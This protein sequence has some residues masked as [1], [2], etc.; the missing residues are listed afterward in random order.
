[1]RRRSGDSKDRIEAF[2]HGSRIADG[3]P[4]VA[5]RNPRH[6]ELFGARRQCCCELTD[7]PSSTAAFWRCR[8]SPL[9]VGAGEFVGVI[10][11]EPCREVDAPAS[12]FR[13]SPGQVRWYFLRGKAD[14][15]DRFAPAPRTGDRPRP[16]GS[17]GVSSTDRA[18]EPDFG[19]VTLGSRPDRASRMEFV[20]E[21]FPRMAERRTQAAGTPLRGEGT[22]VGDR[23]GPDAQTAIAFTD[24]PSINWRR[25]SSTRS[26]QKICDIQNLAG[27]APDRTTKRAYGS[28]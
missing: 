23:S 5:V 1:M 6:R 21:M 7:S 2:Q 25:S 4:E 17:P 22:D 14:R 18:G 16:R 28:A 3:T 9:D 20:Y 19:A 26:T 15:R 24:E 10:G 13:T 11:A 27:G 8:K 12:H